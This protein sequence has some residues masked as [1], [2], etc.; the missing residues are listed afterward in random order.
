MPMALRK[1]PVLYIVGTHT[2][3]THL[4]HSPCVLAS[5]R[6]KSRRTAL[7]LLPCNQPPANIYH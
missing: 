3:P 6:M 2:L 5:G 4:T 1:S 7:H